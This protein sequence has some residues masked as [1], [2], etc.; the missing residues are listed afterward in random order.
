VLE[1]QEHDPAFGV[2][3]ARQRNESLRRLFRVFHGRARGRMLRR[4]LR[5]PLESALAPPSTTNLYPTFC[6]LC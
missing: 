1:R 5:L 3:S 4:G 6:Y 2:R